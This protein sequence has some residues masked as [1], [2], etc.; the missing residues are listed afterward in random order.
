MHKRSLT[1]VQK[2]VSTLVI[3]AIVYLF[4][5]LILYSI[6]DS[7]ILN[8]LITFI[9]SISTAMVLFKRNL[10]PLWIAI[11][12]DISDSIEILQNG[13]HLEKAPT[14]LTSLSLHTIQILTLLREEN[15][16]LKEEI[17]DLKADFEKNQRMQEVEQLHMKL[18]ESQ[19]KLALIQQE[20]DKA[21]SV[22]SEFLSNISHELRTPM[23]GIIGMTELLLDT[24]INHEQGTFLEIV[25][26]SGYNL[27]SLINNVLDFSY[28]ESDN[29]EIEIMDFNIK[30]T[31]KNIVSV[32]TIKAEEKGIHFFYSIDS[33]V[34]DFIK[35]DPGRIR[36]LL[37]NILGNAV[38]FT[39]KG[40]ITFECSLIAENRPPTIQFTVKDTGVGIPVEYQSKLFEKF[41]QAD[42]SHTRSFGGT[43]IGLAL[44]YEL[45]N[46]MNGSISIASKVNNGTEV[47]I[48]LPFIETDKESTIIDNI[49]INDIKILIV[50]DNKSNLNIYRNIFSSLNLNFNLFSSGEEALEELLN[51]Q[52]KGTPYDVA[53]IDMQ[54][55][56]MSGLEVGNLIHKHETLHTTNLVL[57]SSIAR[58]GDAKESKN[59]GFDAFLSKPVNKSDI[60]D[61]LKLIL[62][63]KY[64]KNSDEKEL[65]TVHTIRE[66]RILTKNI[67][68]VE[69]NRTNIIIASGILET[70]GYQYEV[71]IDGVEAL[72]KLE[73][74]YYDL[75]LMDLEMPKLNGLDTASIIR[76]NRSKAFSSIPIIAMTA[77]SD[78]KVI[79]ECKEAGMNDS[80][81]KPISATM[82]SNALQKWL[83]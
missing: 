82:V 17:N 42:G 63:N 55:P 12:E 14:E 38:K 36:Q 53:F 48:N 13:T 66:N 2:F 52:R 25:K 35:S 22:K 27:L 67:L 61:C 18:L 60:V 30:S 32:I 56:D 58:K 26:N 46:L 68:L 8:N 47:T 3:I 83:G 72:E 64:S 24:E 39:N 50:D 57:L 62:A 10:T 74:S 54:M 77:N 16:Q 51:A 9:V 78:P 20:L 44:S 76:S 5:S 4:S 34:P 29:L 70:L 33:N 11:N 7:I 23:N 28:I 15:D 65:I 81:V 6:L 59:V 49:D 1:L 45:V 19:K 71:A 31:L 80:L 21:N 75:I 69:D 37:N 40:E 73:D 79:K 41:S 43:G